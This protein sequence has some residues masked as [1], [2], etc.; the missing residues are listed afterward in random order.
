[1]TRDRLDGVAV[2]HRVESAFGRRD[3]ERLA[4]PQRPLV[5]HAVREGDRLD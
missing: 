2:L 3:D 1:M 4:E 5:G